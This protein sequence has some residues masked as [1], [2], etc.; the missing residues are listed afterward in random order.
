MITVGGV[1]EAVGAALLKVVVADGEAEVRDVTIVEFDEAAGGQPGDLVLGAGL[2]TPEQALVVIERCAQAGA[3]GLVLK[4]SLATHADV[5]SAAAE[6]KLALVELRSHGSWAQLVWLLRGVIDRAA[7]PGTADTAAAGVY[8]EMF[9]LA[10]A[11]AAV[12]DAPVTIEDA[13][14]RVLAYSSRQDR[15]DPARVSTIVGRRVPG[16][17]VARLRSRGVFRRLARSGDPIFVPQGPD[18]TLPR[19]VIPIRAGGELLGSIW[20]VV[21]G[22]VPAERLRDLQG[23]ASVLA[24]HLLRLRVQADVARRVTADRLRAALRTVVQ[25][26]PELG[27]PDGPWRVVALGAH[28][29]TG[30][31]LH[32]LA[33]WESIARRHG[34]RQPLIADVGD[35]LFAVVAARGESPGSWPWLEK[36]IRGVAVHDPGLRAASGSLAAG[37]ADLPR[38]RAEAAELLALHGAARHAGPLLL[39][40]DAWAEVVVHR[41][42]A[43]VPTGDLLVGGPLPDLL[44]HDREHDTAYVATLAAWL[45]HWGDPQK[46]ARHLHVHPNTLR[47]RLRRIAEVVHLDVESPQARLA[48]QIQLAAVNPGRDRKL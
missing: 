15:T 19:L 42:V 8:D 6:R 44:A 32:N 38:S 40:E 45:D 18:G 31:M 43:A 4:P 39:F 1:V 10:D 30:E 7:A 37:L 36:L 33:L 35:V 13:Q 11:A 41:A 26:G 25:P 3:A 16:D 20:A 14:S 34:W 24:L 46:T 29:G 28:V 9:A 48:L 22:P 23:P 47:Y 5:T 2:A 27:L 12:V 17:V 21:E